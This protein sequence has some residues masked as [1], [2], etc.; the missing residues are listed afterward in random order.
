MTG[1]RGGVEPVDDDRYRVRFGKPI[2]AEVAL[3]YF[4]FYPDVR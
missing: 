1:S 2:E 4:G 3:M